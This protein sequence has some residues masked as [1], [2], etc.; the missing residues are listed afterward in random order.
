MK[1]GS[2]MDDA[3]PVSRTDRRASQTYSIQQTTE[4]ASFSPQSPS[5][6]RAGRGPTRMGGIRRYSTRIMR[7][8]LKALSENMRELAEQELKATA[9][10]CSSVE[11]DAN[12][13]SPGTSDDYLT[14]RLPLPVMASAGTKSREPASD[15][16]RLAP[17]SARIRLVRSQDLWAEPQTSTSLRCDYCG[18]SFQLQ[19]GGA[20]FEG[21]AACTNCEQHLNRDIVLPAVSRSRP[22]AFDGHAA[23]PQDPVGEQSLNG[24]AEEAVVVG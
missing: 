19:D 17:K 20:L 6:R 24:T 4:A 21:K 3:L 14:P 8:I 10:P 2:P 11:P 5:P 7:E 18:D 16:D 13:A 9:G 12:T 1:S 23:K 15:A 22:V